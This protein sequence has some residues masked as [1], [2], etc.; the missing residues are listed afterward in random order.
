MLPPPSAG[1]SPCGA[2]P[3]FPPPLPVRPVDTTLLP[4]QAPA[5]PPA[6]PARWTTSPTPPADWAESL[7]ACSGTFF[8]APPVLQAS[9]PPGEAVYARLVRGPRTLAVALG[10]AVRCRLSRRVRHYRF[11]ALPA[12]APGVDRDRAAARLV[13]L[14]SAR[15]AAEVVMESF[16]AGSEAGAADGGIPGR[17]RLELA[18]PLEGGPQAVLM[19]MRGSHRRHVREGEREGWEMRLLRG[20]EA[21]RLLAT[22]RDG[23]AERAALRG[24]GFDAGL[25]AEAFGWATERTAPWGVAT[26]AAYEDGVPLAATSVGWAGGG[27]YLL[28]GGSTPEGYRRSAAHWLQWRLMTELHAAGIRT[29]NLGGVPAEAVRPDHPAHGLYSY[30]SGFGA[31]ETACRGMRWEP[32]PG[33]LRLHGWLGR[34][35]GGR[36]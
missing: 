11:A 29:H 16:G 5:A 36:L 1:G 25:P 9:L 20:G 18:I 15:G 12:A 10:A 19:R 4:P 14:L 35:T 7:A 8:H 13:E 17:G 33:H 28:S 26:F 22:V 34:M 2:A 27:S 3:P 32:H 30:K 6:A 31:V 23:A 21:L 24:D